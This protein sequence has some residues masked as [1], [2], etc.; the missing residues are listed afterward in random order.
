[1]A[2]IDYYFTTV[3]PWAYL[4]GD[5]LETMAARHGATVTYK[6]VDLGKVFSATGGLPLKQ[7]SQARQDY[8]LQELARAQAKTGLPLTIHPAHFPTNPAPSSYAIIAAQK[9]G[10]DTAA[11][12]QNVLR[13]CWAE[14]R[15]IAEDEVIRDCLSA[16]GF[17]PGL[18][19]SGLLA[20][21]TTYEAYTEEAIQEG[22][23]GSPFYVVDSGQKFWG[24]DR[25]DDLESHLAGR[26]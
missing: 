4:A 25:L 26:L 11:L 14:D 2:H 23:F 17:D 21:A 13:A 18:A 8:R 5:R 12:V 16:A 15:N 10:G 24:Q 7:R 6:P 1:M 9:A 19:D 3:S 20:G 22:V